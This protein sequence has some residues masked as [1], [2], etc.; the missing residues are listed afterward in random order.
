MRNWKSDSLE[1]FIYA[2]RMLPRHP[3]SNG[4][5]K[6]VGIRIHLNPF[7]QTVCRAARI[8]PMEALRCE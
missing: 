2:A 5:M 8:H 6:P 1:D 3:L 4:V 7:G